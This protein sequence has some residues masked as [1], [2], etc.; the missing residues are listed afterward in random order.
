[1]KIKLAKSAGFCF[2]VKRAINIALETAASKQPTYMLGDI[3]H[4]E[5]V[6]NNMRKAGIKKIESLSSG[7]GKILLISAHGTSKKIFNLAKRAGFKIVDATCPMVREIQKTASSMELE[8][9]RIIIIG[10]KN[11][12]EVRGIAGQLKSRATVIEDIE[13]LDL[14]HL[15]G[16][17]KAAVV[18]QSTQKLDKVLEIVEAIKDK[19][20]EVRFFNTICKPTTLRQEEIRR[21]PLENDCILIIGSKNSANT[22]RLYEIAKSLNPSSY[23]IN[24][25]KEIKKEWFKDVSSVGITSGASTPDSTTEGVIKF[26]KKLKGN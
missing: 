21:M 17:P 7:K 11:H 3:V 5:E 23:W 18:A 2:G 20:K 12:D 14:C 6:V 4:N 26:L 15:K 24:G 1:M 13:A 19:V 9:F 25:K 10:D 16:I 22:K 8:G